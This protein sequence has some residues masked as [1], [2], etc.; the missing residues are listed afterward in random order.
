VEIHTKDENASSWRRRAASGVSIAILTALVLGCYA[1]SLWGSP[2][3]GRLADQPVYLALQEDYLRA[4]Q[5][6]E[7]IPRWA[8]SANGGRGSPTFVLYPPLS[9][10][11]LSLL[12]TVC[13]LSAVE[14]LRWGILVWAFVTGASVY[15]L[16]RSWLSPP[17]S[18]VAAAAVLLL[19]GTTFVC[20]ARGMYPQF[21]AL[22]WTALLIG[23]GLRILDGRRTWWNAA[24][25]VL[26]GAGLIL[27]H[28]IS[29]Y[30]LGLLL[31]LAA[32]WLWP[33][34]GPRRF[35]AAALLGL[36]AVA[37]TSWFW[38]PQLHGLS[39]TRAQ[40]LQQRHPY[41]DSVFFAPGAAETSYDK[42][43]SFINQVGRMIAVGQLILGLSLAL[44]RP[45]MIQAPLE[46]ASAKWFLK[47]LPWFAAFTIAALL[48][49]IATL[50]LHLPGYGM[51]QFGWR[52][53][54]LLSLWVGVSLAAVP[55]RVDAALP[56]AVAVGVVLFFS[57][58]LL[59]ARAP[60]ARDEASLRP[61]VDEETMQRLPPQRRALYLNGL[62]EHRP[63]GADSLYYLAAAS[64]QAEM[65]SGDSV[66]ARKRIRTSER[67]YWIESRTASQMRILT[68]DCPGWTAE[69]DGREA[70]IEKEC[71][72]GLQL[73]GLEPGVHHVSLKFRTP[74]PSLSGPLPLRT[75]GTGCTGTPPV[76]DTPARAEARLLHP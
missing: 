66:I 56:I 59:P 35:L 70:V 33:I 1:L 61:A 73:L 14:G 54:M 53:Q 60:L 8:A 42:D 52:W 19:P 62:A 40:F 24:L 58:L 3:F 51:V 38:I 49:P 36:T 45:S 5:D 15:F 17:R 63:L 39:Y 11:V 29:A 27:T 25:L 44:V 31:L 69:L 13:R 75:A 16:A 72:S 26:A 64:G 23:A 47:V 43:W 50:L 9:F 6:G 67:E 37:L 41:M 30:L 32:P 71:G 76:P 28:T 55:K 18:A 34:L 10:A 7:W 12:S 74:W 2:A 22:A 46:K 20:L 48:P 57:A 21:F 68:Y 65:V 4:L